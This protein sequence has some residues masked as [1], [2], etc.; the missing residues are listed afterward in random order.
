[1]R[2][3]FLYSILFLSFFQAATFARGGGKADSYLRI[4][5]R[6]F[7]DQRF[8]Y[9]IPFYK[10]ALRNNTLKDSL[11]LSHLAESYWQ[12]K[13]FDSARIYY[14]VFEQKFGANFL[15][16]HRL[17]EL[18]A[19][20]KKYADA[21]RIYQKIQKDFPGT[22]ATLVTHRLK[23]FADVSP[24]LKDSLDY[25]LHLLRLNTGQQD[26]SPQFYRDGMVFV[27][28]RYT[29][30]HPEKE[31]GWDGLPFADIYWV[32]DTSEL[33][34]VDSMPPR[35]EPVINRA[36]KAN[37]DYTAPTS[38]DNDIILVSNMRGA[39][40][41]AEIHKLAKFTDDLDAKYNYGPLCF[42]KSG[43]K[44]YFTR[45]TLK[46]YKG[47]YNLEVCE[48]SLVT[49][50][51]WGP[52][53]V[54]PFVEEAYDFYHPALSADQARLY[55]CSNRPGGKGGSDIYY[56]DLSSDSAMR[57][58]VLLDDKV[59]TS[60]DELFPTIF[61]DTLY[62][63]S[64]GHAGLGGLDLYRTTPDN[65]SWK[66]PVNLGYPINSPYDDFGIIFSPD[67]NEGFLTSNR[68]GSDDIYRFT[69]ATIMIKLA[70]HV[71]DRSTMRRLDSAK[72][73]IREIVNEKTVKD[74]V[75]TNFTGN[76]KFPIKVNHDYRLYFTRDGYTQDSVI[77][78]K[79]ILARDIELPPVL[80][81]PIP[82]P[83]PPVVVAAIKDRDG[84]GVEDSKD[85]CPTKKGLTDNSG[86]P[87][88]Q[89]RLNELAKMVHFKTASA[90]LTPEAL[91]PLIEA[92]E[93]LTEYPNTTLAIEG[94][95]DSRASAPYNKD[96]SQRRA[97]SV[98]A[99]FVQKGLKPNRF[100][101]VV[102][103]GLERP[104]ADN[105]TEEGRAM[106]RRVFIQAT[107]IF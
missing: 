80:L 24:F 42:N 44:V 20:Q 22:Q 6:E 4:A 91:K 56:V 35:T 87:D 3:A 58:P 103:Y 26:F 66:T 15:S 82:K 68:L 64:D 37:D 86:C 5:E 63:S 9:A 34:A 78:N 105:K 55:F 60:G 102:G 57:S 39:Y 71:V 75:I 54:L 33:F 46:A 21:A 41:T 28:N 65:N 29:K 40:H 32:K 16:S 77:M 38:N 74:S 84:D 23:G 94:H 83:A 79:T 104:I 107:F 67:K 69:E 72:C 62:F 13:N 81:S 53:K 97:N 51:A 8:M 14:Q 88:I 1:M 19:I 36:I 73:V 10:S 50:G 25:T 96:L 43:N 70:G 106:N 27:S 49:G 90:E 59:N 100:T 76:F 17:G 7:R 48:A 52:I 12:V 30:N 31:F 61:G 47:K 18:A 45:N 2:K 89:S 101:S 99:F 98:K 92:A 95:T 85:K 11:A 93:I